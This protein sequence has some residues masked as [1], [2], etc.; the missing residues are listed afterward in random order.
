M[1]AWSRIVSMYFFNAALCD[2]GAIL[3]S[4][5][6]TLVG[7]L[8][9]SAYNMFRDLFLALVAGVII[10]GILLAEKVVARCVVEMDYFPFI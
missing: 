10:L 5:Y 2:I 4:G 8:A 7:R 9:S 6:F 3:N 1:T